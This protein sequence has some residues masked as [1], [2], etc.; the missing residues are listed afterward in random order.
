MSHEAGYARYVRLTEEALRAALGVPPDTGFGTQSLRRAMAYSLFAGGKRLRPVL[1]L[2]AYGM[3]EE[4][5][6]PALAFAAAV[7]MI[8]TYSL[9]HD[10]LPAMDNDS[11]RRGRPTCH[12]AFG[13]ALAILAGDALLNGAYELMAQSPHPRAL[14]ALREV[15]ARAGDL[16]MIGGQAADVV[17]E[18]READAEN[19]LYIHEHKTAALMTAPVMC[20]LT[21]AGAQAQDREAGLRYGRYLGL[22]FQIVDDLLDMRTEGRDVEAGKLTWP[23]VHG[24]ERAV[25]DARRFTAVAVEAAN[26]FG[27]RG[28]FLAE[29]ARRALTR[30]Q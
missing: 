2:A 9:I 4:D 11:L 7:E 17:Q 19:L 8:H 15:A 18:G 20:A 27:N 3:Y 1:L 25:E 24:G 10:D 13:E 26:A 6:G 12:R 23:S 5:L 21:L 16:G 29:L 30:V 14:P 22:A 28:V